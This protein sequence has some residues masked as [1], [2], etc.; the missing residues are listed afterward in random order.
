MTVDGKKGRNNKNVRQK[1]LAWGEILVE[2]ALPPSGGEMVLS[3]F[4]VEPGSTKRETT[5]RV[6]M[7]SSLSAER[8][9]NTVD[10]SQEYVGRRERGQRV[11]DSKWK[12]KYKN[13]VKV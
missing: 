3:S 13:E 4:R 8:G 12:G 1:E 10:S 7:L 2:Q 5:H 11:G 9:D 6:H